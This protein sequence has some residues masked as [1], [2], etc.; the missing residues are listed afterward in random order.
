MTRARTSQPRRRYYLLRLLGMLPAAAGVVLALGAAAPSAAPAATPLVAGARVAAPG[1][2]WTVQ[3]GGTSSAS[4]VIR[5]KVRDLTTG[6]GYVC[7]TS[8]TLTFKTGSGLPG[9]GIASVPS[10]SADRC[11][12][13][14]VTAGNLPWAVNATQY[15]P[16]AGTTTG[17][18]TRFTLRFSGGGCH[19]T[20]GNP[21]TTSHVR[22]RYINSTGRLHLSAT[23]GN[24]QF[25]GVSGCPGSDNGD[26]ASVF[27]NYF[28]T[29][30]Q[31]V[32]SP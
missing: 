1:G 2:T 20:V 13:F 18:L 16:A 10:F 31:T 7:A 23:G 25:F 29:P 28:L 30:S 4:D 14:T 19:F 32:T 21:A 8:M 5:M 15:H 24:L 11:H 27:D 17:T 3:P 9:R 22:F 12:G 6:G 26:Q